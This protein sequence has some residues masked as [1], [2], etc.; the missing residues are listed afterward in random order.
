MM[1]AHRKVALITGGSRGIGRATAVHLSRLGMQVVVGYHSDIAAAQS[2]IEEMEGKE[3]AVCRISLDEPATIEGARHLVAERYGRLDILVNS[4]GWTQPVPMDD[5][6]A[7][8]DDLFDAVVRINLRGPFAV[9]R[10]FRPLL[11]KSEDGVIVNVSSLSAK[12][13]I[14]SNLAYCAAKG[15]LDTLT[16]GLARLLGP[17]IRVFSISPGGVDTDFVMDRT[18]AQL[19]DRAA[20]TPLKKVTMPDDVARSIEA[21]ITHLTS[22]TGITLIVDEGRHL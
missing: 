8:T 6:D 1:D 13:G 14:G 21:A 12:S 3:H 7:L 9:I 20:A 19:E 18:R 22:T 5:L 15:G 4:G 17:K 16:V 10:A 2:L 11:D